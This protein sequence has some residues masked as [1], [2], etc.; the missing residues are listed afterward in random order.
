M[1][2]KDERRLEFEDAIMRDAHRWRLLQAQGLS[3]RIRPGPTS[4]SATMRTGKSIRS[5][6]RMVKRCGGT[7]RLG[8]GYDLRDG[9]CSGCTGNEARN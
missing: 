5:S 6:S 8:G 3:L 7:Q 2:S 4:I 9:R 1:A